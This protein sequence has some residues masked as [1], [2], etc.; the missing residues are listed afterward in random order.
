MA[1]AEVTND[2][3]KAG[4]GLALG[5]CFF[6][7]DARCYNQ[8]R[9]YDAGGQF[10]GFHSKTLTCGSMDDPPEGEINDYAVAPLRS[11]EIKGTIIG[12]LICNDL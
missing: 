6:E 11:Y 7:T 3:V 12:G 4:V 10:L 1:L 2:A 9:F 5:T 8:I